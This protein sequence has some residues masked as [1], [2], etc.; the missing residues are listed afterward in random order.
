MAD[1]KALAALSQALKLEKEGR[2]F[3]LK[4]AEELLDSRGKALFAS[5]ADDELKHAEMIQRQLH[6]IEGG[7]AYVLLPDLSAPDID[8][9]AKLFPPDAKAIERKIGVEPNEL[10]ILTLA[11]ENEIKSYDLYTEAARNETNE[12]GKRMYVWLASAELTHFNLLM[13]N[14]ES[15]SAQGGW[16]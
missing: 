12:A 7:G 4:A 10:E 16:V 11:L 14:W 9:G 2:A 6:M 15:L 1:N 5:L 3:Y 13:S 8:L